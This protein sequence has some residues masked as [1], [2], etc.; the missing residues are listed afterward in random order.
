[1]DKWKDDPA[2]S[3]IKNNVSSIHDISK[4]IGFLLDF[5]DGID[6]YGEDGNGECDFMDSSKWESNIG[7]TL[8]KLCVAAKAYVEG[9]IKEETSD[10]QGGVEYVKKLVIKKL[11]KS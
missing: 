11:V 4:A 5:M 8:D 2:A 1:V 7:E 6:V 3:I 9:L 10:K